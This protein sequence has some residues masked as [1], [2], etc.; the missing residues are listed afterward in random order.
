MVAT[1]SSLIL[2]LTTKPSEIIWAFYKFRMPPTVGLA[3]TAALRFLPQLIERMTVLL[4]VMQVRGYDLTRPGW[5]EVHRWPGYIGRVLSAI[6]IV[7]VP[8]LIGSLRS[9]S[10]M[11]MVADAR[12]FGA[13]PNPTSLNEH[14]QT[15]QDRVAIGALTAV[16]VTALLL[17]VLHIGNRQG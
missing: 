6:P 4:L 10:V 11:A 17:V 1:S 8:L 12:A 3:F 13:K 14:Q 9:T 5:W 2:L 7:T 16:V 15:L